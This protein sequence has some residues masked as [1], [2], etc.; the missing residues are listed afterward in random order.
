MHYSTGPPKPLPLPWPPMRTDDF[1]KRLAALRKE[2][3]LT[4]QG[5]A[6]SIGVHVTQLRRYEAG[7]SQPTLDVL[8]RLAI[9][10]RISAD[11][12]LFDEKER[13][14]VESLRFQFE[15]ASRLDA[16]EIEVVKSVLEGILLKHEAKRLMRAG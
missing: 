15:A 2:R 16:Q 7:T 11:T 5:L 14:P 9:T 6:D 12:L 4:Q 13:G 3:A 1:P 8:R 10:L